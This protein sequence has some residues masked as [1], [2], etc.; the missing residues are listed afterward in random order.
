MNL[1]GYLLNRLQDR[2]SP[3]QKAEEWAK[4][5]LGRAL[6][7]ANPAALDSTTVMLAAAERLRKLPPGT[8]Q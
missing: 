8:E 7:M 1:I 2:K 4:I 5:K 3:A 6:R